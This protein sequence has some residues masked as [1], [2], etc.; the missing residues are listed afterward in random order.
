MRAFTNLHVRSKCSWHPLSG[1]VTQSIQLLMVVRG[2]G[3]R[4]LADRMPKSHEVDAVTM[5]R[6]VGAMGTKCL[7]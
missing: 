7:S 4:V 1:A 2:F 6:L 3:S 5:Q